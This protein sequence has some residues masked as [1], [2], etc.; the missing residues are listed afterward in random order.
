[1]RHRCRRGP[2]GDPEAAFVARDGNAGLP[3]IGFEGDFNSADYGEPPGTIMDALMAA[4]VESPSSKITRNQNDWS[5][6][7]ST[8]LKSAVGLEDF[9]FA[10]GLGPSACARRSRGPAKTDFEALIVTFA[11]A[12]EEPLDAVSPSG[13]PWKRAERPLAFDEC[14]NAARKKCP[15]STSKSLILLNPETDLA[16]K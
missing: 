4:Q 14:D 2:S 10:C 7:P 5:G 16:K 1:M 6:A 11:V 9:N 3:C 15:R 13:S 12:C 8:S